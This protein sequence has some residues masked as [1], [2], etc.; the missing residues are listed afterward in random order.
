MGPS[1]GSRPCS[2]AGWV[3]GASP[4]LST[5]VKEGEAFL[6]FLSFFHF[7]LFVCLLFVMGQAGLES[8]PLLP[9]ALERWD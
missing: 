3:R 1:N 7:S 9:L 6:Q 5:S 4:I 8:R 2:Q